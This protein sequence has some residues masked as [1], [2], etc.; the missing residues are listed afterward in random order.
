MRGRLDATL[1][2][3]ATIERREQ[4]GENEIGEPISGDVIVATDVPCAFDDSSTSFVRADTGERVQ[5]PATATFRA[6]ADLEEGDTITIEDVD[7]TYEVRGLDTTRDHRRGT[8][9][10]ITA[11]LE[12][13]D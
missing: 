2:D 9:V 11:E 6:G 12:R 5:R 8:T 13:S 4:T 1:T 10:S 7:A 3:R